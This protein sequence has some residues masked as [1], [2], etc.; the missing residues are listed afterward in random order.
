MPDEY[1]YGVARA[2]NDERNA[3]DGEALIGRHDQVGT[4]TEQD[5]QEINNVFDNYKNFVKNYNKKVSLINL[6]NHQIL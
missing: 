3:D 5:E 1:P 6:F 4:F 2:T